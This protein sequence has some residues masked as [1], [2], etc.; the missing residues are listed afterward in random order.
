MNISVEF[1]GARGEQGG[2]SK[3][4]FLISEPRISRNTDSEL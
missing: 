2:I 1:K 3:A 4:K